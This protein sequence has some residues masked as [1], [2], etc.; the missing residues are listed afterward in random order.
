MG[1][2]RNK[3]KQP[4]FSRERIRERKEQISY[5]FDKMLSRGSAKLILLLFIVVI[6]VSF[7]LGLGAFIFGAN[8]P[9][10]ELI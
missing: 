10:D 4:F 2:R 5:A 8:E 9:L 7:V 6:F 1:R 3:K